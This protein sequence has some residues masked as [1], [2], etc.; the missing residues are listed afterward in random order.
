MMIGSKKTVL[1]AI[2]EAQRDLTSIRRDI[3][4]STIR[5]QQT[6]L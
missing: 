4:H 2:K 6:V 3:Y 1:E 5:P